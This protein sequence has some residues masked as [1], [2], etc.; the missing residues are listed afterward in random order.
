M[1]Q[2]QLFAPEVCPPRARPR[3]NDAVV[4]E[5][6]A[7]RLLPKLR[8]WGAARDD[9]PID[10]EGALQHLT[11]VLS[12]DDDAYKLAKGLEDRGWDSD[13]GMVEALRDAADERFEALE[14]LVQAWVAEYGIKPPL[15]VG[16]RVTFLRDNVEQ[17]GE[18]TAVHEATAIYT[19]C[20]EALGHVRSGVGTNGFR[21]PY[22]AVSAV[23]PT[24]APQS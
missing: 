1:S 14:E 11:A 8:A 20:C 15:A 3:L 18:V 4:T 13:A 23:P 5:A 2:L 22:E 10:E 16:T 17:A 9:R 24:V 6:T 12:W 19:V 7:R 21:L